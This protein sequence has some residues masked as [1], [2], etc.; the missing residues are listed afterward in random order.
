ME[1][2]A[3][4]SPRWIF[5]ESPRKLNYWRKPNYIIKKFMNLSGKKQQVG[6]IFQKQV[7]TNLVKKY[8]RCNCLE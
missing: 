8:Q 1:L 3:H 2:D 6:H 7:Y 5:E 4:V